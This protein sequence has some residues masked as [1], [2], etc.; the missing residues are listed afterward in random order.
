MTAF[1]KHGGLQRDSTPLTYPYKPLDLTL[2][3]FVKTDDEIVK[4]FE[5]VRMD[6]VTKWVMICDQ[7]T[8]LA[9]HFYSPK[10]KWSIEFNEKTPIDDL[11]KVLTVA[12]PVGFVYFH[13]LTPTILKDGSELYQTAIDEKF[14]STFEHLSTY[15]TRQYNYTVLYN[16][17]DQQRLIEDPTLYEVI[18]GMSTPPYQVES[19]NQKMNVFTLDVTKAYTPL[20][21]IGSKHGTDKSPYHIRMH[22]RHGYTALYHLLF[23]GLR[24]KPIVFGEIGILFGRS[25]TMWREYFH[26]TAKLVAF[27]YDR[28]LLAKTV[29]DTKVFMDVTDEKIIDQALIEGGASYDVLLDD[30]SHTLR[31]QL[32]LI[33][34]GFKYVKPGGMLIIEDIF[35]DIPPNHFRDALNTLEDQIESCDWWNVNHQYANTA[36]WDNNTVLVITK[37]Q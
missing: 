22:D 18:T 13:N 37:R 7:P 1:E 20:C 29:A 16:P 33:Q 35:R 14:W 30:S 10:I 31:D 36:G 8:K 26:K 6:L 4:L 12:K 2:I 15:I 11:S 34:V 24:T 32:R 9:Q 21:H 23:R 27:D 19:L 3:S 28:E 5:S 17:D 25:V